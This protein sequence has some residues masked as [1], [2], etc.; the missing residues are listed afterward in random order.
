ME[1][2]DNFQAKVPEANWGK[3]WSLIVALTT[4]QF[5]VSTEV[6][7]ATCEALSG[8]NPDFSMFSPSD[9]EELAWGVTEVVLNDPPDKEPGNNDFSSEVCT[10][11]GLI[12]EQNGIYKPPAP[13]I[14]ARYPRGNPIMDQETMFSNDPAMFAASYQNQQTLKE[15]IENFVRARAAELQA[16]LDA[17]P[18]NNRVK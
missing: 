15:N 1:V 6:Y 16:Q 5:Y 11:T 9:P 17:V 7:R 2:S 14:F 3:I 13:L 10:Y 12:L 18:L 4:N 8:G